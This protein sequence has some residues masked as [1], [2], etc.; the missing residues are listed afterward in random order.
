MKNNEMTKFIAHIDSYFQQEDCTIL[1]SSIT[2]PHID[3]LF[4]KPNDTYPYWKLVTMGASDYQMPP[5]KPSLGNRNEYMMFI[6]ANE[7]LDN[8]IIRNEYYHY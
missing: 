8:A 5:Q 4:Y 3:V 2:D 6:D 7:D 1:H